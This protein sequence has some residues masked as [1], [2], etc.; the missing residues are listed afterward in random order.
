MDGGDGLGARIVN[1]EHFRGLLDGEIFKDNF[2]EEKLFDFWC[3]FG[4]FF[5]VTSFQHALIGG[6][7]LLELRLHHFVIKIIELSL[8]AVFKYDV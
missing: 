8:I 7:M 6:R 5:F 1:S 4:I 3:K 2:S